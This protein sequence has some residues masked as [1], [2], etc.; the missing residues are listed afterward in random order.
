MLNQLVLFASV[1]S[2]I[3]FSISV[4]SLPS[5]LVFPFQAAALVVLVLQVENLFDFPRRGLRWLAV[6]LLPF[7]FLIWVAL[8][9]HGFLLA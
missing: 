6:L 7:V 1:F 4:P 8:Q 5:Y 3:V 9:V 2:L